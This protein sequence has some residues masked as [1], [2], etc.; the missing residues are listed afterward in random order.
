MVATMVIYGR[1]F[2]EGN[3]AQLVFFASQS[4]LYSVVAVIVNVPGRDYGLLHF[5]SFLFITRIACF[6]SRF[7]RL[8]KIHRYKGLDMKITK[9]GWLVSIEIIIYAIFYTK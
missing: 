5:L 6:S 9:R 7:L 4:R 8:C 2:T 1:D 3:L